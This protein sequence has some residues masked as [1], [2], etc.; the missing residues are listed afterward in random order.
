MTPNGGLKHC[1]S[2]QRTD[3]VL[4]TRA[5]ICGR[6]SLACLTFWSQAAAPLMS[7]SS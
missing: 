5:H 7:R 1:W 2:A 3:N 4:H 6:S